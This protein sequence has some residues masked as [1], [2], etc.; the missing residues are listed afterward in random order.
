NRLMLRLRGGKGWQLNKVWLDLTSP[1]HIKEAFA[2]TA[3]LTDTAV[4]NI[5][6]KL[7]ADK[8]ANTVN[9]R[10]QGRVNVKI[11]PWSPKEQSDPVFNETFPIT[12][13]AYKTEDFSEQIS[14]LNPKKWTPDNPNLYKVELNLINSEGQFEDAYVFTTGIRAVG[15]EN[16]VFHL[17]GTPTP[18]FGANLTDYLPFEVDTYTTPTVDM[19]RWIVRAVA[20]IKAMN[21]N[22]VRTPEL[23]NINLERLA[24][25]CDQMGL[26]LIKQM[27][28]PVYDEPWAFDFEAA[29]DQ[30]IA[31]RHHPSII[32][33]QAP[34]NLRFNN[35][36]Q[37]ASKWME[38]FFQNMRFY[39]P[40]TLV[41][42]TGANTE[43]GDSAIPNDEG[44]RLYESSLRR[45]RLLSNP[46]VW[47]SPKVIRNNADQAISKGKDWDDLRTFPVDYTMD[48]LRLNYLKSPTHLYLDLNSENLA[49]QE[50]PLTVRGT[51]Y[52]YSES[53]QSPYPNRTVGAEI[54]FE[55][56][57]SSQGLQ[58][59][60][61]YEALR[62]KRWL[63]YD[64]IL[65]GTLWN[66]G[67]PTTLLD[68]RGFAKLGYHTSQMAFQAALA[69][70]RTTDLAYQV[71]ET[72]PIFLNY[73]GK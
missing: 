33:W 10:W 23:K 60:S 35:Y 65:A 51:P 66:G 13:R 12:L 39:S 4:L 9:G 6:A 45:Y 72:I 31:L 53:Y 8:I 37:D 54:I 41:S 68:A 56:W 26:M 2:Y 69:G 28:A 11:T 61:N 15:Q 34:D 62:K 63:G 17:N 43:F 67:D 27:E 16:G 24:S 25:I 71:G 30:V 14:L 44:N 29:R 59:F 52:R 19:D 40:S 48:T 42:L 58:G 20:S 22:V 73:I 38:R 55:N 18:L 70:S 21:G 32:L 1:V 3:S 46:S 5:Q 50:N 7:Q 47:T 49:G 64:G 57:K 36:L